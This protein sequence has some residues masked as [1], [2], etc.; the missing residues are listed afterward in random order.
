MP[1]DHTWQGSRA[2]RY[3]GPVPATSSQ[4]TAVAGEVIGLRQ[5]ATD[6]G[7]TDG[8]HEDLPTPVRRASEAA[9]RPAREPPTT[10][11]SWGNPLAPSSFIWTV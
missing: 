4:S 9:D 2:I 10:S 5:F 11:N 1:A 6:P 3:V 8:D 7:V